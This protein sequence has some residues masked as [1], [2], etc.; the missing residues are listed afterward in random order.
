[1]ERLL[2]LIE[3]SP[4][5]QR[6][7]RRAWR[8]SQ[9]LGGELDLL[10]VKK[11]GHTP[12]REERDQLDAIGR[13][14][15]VLGAH[16]LV[17]E[18]DDLVQTAKEVAEEKGSTYV[19]IGTPAPAR[20][21]RFKPALSTRLIEAMPGVDLRVVADR[22]LRGE[23]GE[24]S[25]ALRCVVVALFACS[26][27]YL[28]VRELQRRRTAASITPAAGRI[29]F[30]FVGEAL[31]TP[32]FDAALRLARAEGATLVPAYLAIVPLSVHLDTPLRK[33]AE[34]A[35]PLLEAIEQRATKQG[36]PVDSRIEPGRSVAPRVPP[37][38]EP[39]AV[40]PGGGW[41]APRTGTASAPRTSRGCWRTPPVRSSCCG[42]PESQRR[43]TGPSACASGS[44]THGA[45]QLRATRSI[46]ARYGRRSVRPNSG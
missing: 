36:V 22:S 30:P 2:A 11:P 38:G 31:S 40:R 29:L 20:L 1:M 16:L 17:E 15:A 14:A 4:R 7:V 21:D 26:I 45:V 18:G 19:L 6:L 41:R 5:A 8:S 9:R 12:T 13:L 34:A 3:P 23:E 35:L 43:T 27:G 39:R 37:A 10:W 46:A 42:P 24:M 33:Q 44:G 28:L 32:A 25:A